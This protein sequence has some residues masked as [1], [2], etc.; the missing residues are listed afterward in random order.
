[1]HSK[2]RIFLIT[3]ILASLAPIPTIGAYNKESTLRITT[4]PTKASVYVDKRYIGASP[5]QINMSPGKYSFQAQKDYVRG[6]V[7]V[8]NIYQRNGTLV[9]FV[10]EKTRPTKSTKITAL[11]SIP[12]SLPTS[13]DYLKPGIW[14]LNNSQNMWGSWSLLMLAIGTIQIISSPQHP[15]NWGMITGAFA[16]NALDLFRITGLIE[17]GVDLD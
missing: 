9:L 10:S 4:I 7:V 1:M 8:K 6:P 13:S 16:L 5:I 17:A 12:K 11:P 3:L 14:Q 2:L 15:E